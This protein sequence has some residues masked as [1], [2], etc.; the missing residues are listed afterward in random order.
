MLLCGQRKKR[1]SSDGLPGGGKQQ[2]G[3]NGARPVRSAEETETE[4]GALI[5]KISTREPGPWRDLP[6]E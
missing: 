4:A 6:Q 2:L 1:S 5:R 3:L